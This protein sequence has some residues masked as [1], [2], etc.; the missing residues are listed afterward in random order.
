M[1]KYILSALFS[2]TAFTSF[3]QAPV[4]DVER[5]RVESIV[6]EYLMKNPEII[7]EALQAMELKQAEAEEK[8]RSERLQ[9][10][11]EA[12]YRPQNTLIFGNPKGDV[13]LV[14]FFDY[15][16]GFCK[17]GF[18]DVQNLMKGDKNIRVIFR[19]FPVLGQGSMEAARIAVAVKLQATHEKFM[20]FHEKLLMGRGAANHDKAMDAAKDAGIDMAR[21]DAD[22][23]TDT[24]AKTIQ[25]NMKIGDSLK[26]T[27]TP[28]YVVGNDVIIGAVGLETLKQKAEESRKACATD[29][30][31]CN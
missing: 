29:K 15:N 31:K 26:I 9:Q 19:D 20:V 2:L 5:K 25:E 6:R 7:N 1:K 14:E 11:K 27:G 22:M 12:L 16:C 30:A 24:I 21:L 10:Y 23:K 28:S 8:S 4:S 13:T 18:T 3:A 17:R